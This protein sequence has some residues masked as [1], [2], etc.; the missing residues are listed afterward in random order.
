MPFSMGLMSFTNRGRCCHGMLTHKDRVGQP[1]TCC[2]L[3]S[4]SAS[5]ISN[6]ARRFTMEIGTAGFGTKAAGWAAAAAGAAAG[7]A[8]AAAGP[9][10]GGV[11]ATSGS[12]HGVLQSQQWRGLQMGSCTQML[13]ISRKTHGR[14]GLSMLAP[15][16]L[17][18]QAA[19]WVPQIAGLTL[20]AAVA[21]A[22]R[23]SAFRAAPVSCPAPHPQPVACVTACA[24]QSQQ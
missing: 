10:A 13:C 5:S 22:S 2:L 12:S 11:P 18:W 19:L 9:A 15:T 16:M 7:A 17:P 20:P 6:C 1:V 4:F 3:S 24:P 23:P 21:A 14:C 8:A